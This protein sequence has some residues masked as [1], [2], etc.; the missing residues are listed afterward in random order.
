MKISRNILLIQNSSGII[1]VVVN[2]LS[3][4]II[5]FLLFCGVVVYANEVEP[6]EKKLPEIRINYFNISITTDSIIY[7]TTC[8]LLYI[9]TNGF[10]M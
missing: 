4:V 5:V 9:F 2:F 10:K 8:I 1:S 7:L 6:K 3:Q